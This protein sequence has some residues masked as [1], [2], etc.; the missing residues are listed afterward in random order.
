MSG[1]ARKTGEGARPEAELAGRRQ[2]WGVVS[3]VSEAPELVAA[4]AAHALSLGAAEV[5]LYLDEPAPEIERM[6]GSNP[7]VRLVRCD[8][9]Y[10][11]GLGMARPWV[12][13]M[14][15]RAN[16]KVELDAA[17]YPWLLH[18][19]ADEF[20]WG[21]GDM[22]E[23]LAAQPEE[24]GFLLIPVAERVHSG[25][26]DAANV[27]GGRFRRQV[28]GEAEAAIARL[29]GPA[30]PFLDQGMA[31]YAGGKSFFRSGGRAAS[32]VHL[33]DG[34]GEP[35][36]VLYSH[37]ILH[38]DGLTPAGWVAKKRR[39][40]AQQPEWRSF[41]DSHRATRNQLA[42]V[43]DATD[44][45]AAALVYAVIKELDPAREAALAAQG[46]LLDVELHLPAKI[47]AAFPGL[48][49]DLSAAALDRHVMAYRP[50]RD[51]QAV[52]HGL[53][54]MLSRWTGRRPR[55]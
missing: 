25:P 18:I 20:L 41:P 28:G 17:R 45:A 39:A 35:L 3:T 54:A 22:G 1:Q 4:F 36:N 51:F 32:G 14:R 34:A 40:I 27:F 9:A 50:R 10:W 19:D 8:A 33:P 7:R 53:R 2:D 11:A 26:A 13:A 16:L 42:A 5:C 44:D 47:E 43:H 21:P 49:L 38:F 29:D 31:G 24:T 12:P 55:A 52:K 6:L 48:A 15:Q 46:I 30:A 37:L 23:I